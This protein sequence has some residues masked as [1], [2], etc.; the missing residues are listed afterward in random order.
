MG[1][2]RPRLH[3][4]G[5]ERIILALLV[6]SGRVEGADIKEGLRNKYQGKQTV[7]SLVSVPGQR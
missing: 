3:T 4:L 6:T 7:K 2:N 5:A 1:Q